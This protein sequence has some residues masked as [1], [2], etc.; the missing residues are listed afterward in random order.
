M[1]MCT[2]L[3]LSLQAFPCLTTVALIDSVSSSLSFAR[4]CV[5]TLFCFVFLGVWESP[6]SVEM[7][8]LIFYSSS[9]VAR[10]SRP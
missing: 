10:L 4:S 3:S 9:S 8:S 6:V 1:I 5:S 2:S 7:S